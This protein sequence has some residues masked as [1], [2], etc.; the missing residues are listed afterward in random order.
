MSSR[1]MLVPIVRTYIRIHPGSTMPSV[2]PKS[3]G[4]MAL[5]IGVSQHSRESRCE[6]HAKIGDGSEG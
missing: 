3:A 2:D 1:A 5:A 6:M 4:Y